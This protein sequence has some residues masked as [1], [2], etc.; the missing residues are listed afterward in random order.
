VGDGGGGVQEIRND[1]C[2][3]HG[4]SL[5]FKASAVPSDCSPGYFGPVYTQS[6]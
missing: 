1:H 2:L 6:R 3:G 5:T 4:S